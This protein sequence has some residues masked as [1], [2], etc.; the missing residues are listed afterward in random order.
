MSASTAPISKK[1]HSSFKS[2]GHPFWDYAAVSLLLGVLLW[3]LCTISSLGVTWDEHYHL[4]W[5]AEKWENYIN[6]FSGAINFSEFLQLRQSSVHPGF[7]DL[8]LQALIRGSSLDAGLASHLLSFSFGFSGLVAVWLTGRRLLGAMGGFF[9]LFLLIT[10]PRYFGHMWFNPKDIPFAACYMWSLYCLIRVVEGFPRPGWGACLSFGVL[11]GLSLGV[12]MAGLLLFCY[13]AVACCMFLGLHRQSLRESMSVFGGFIG[14]GLLS[15]VSAYLCVL[16][17]WPALWKSPFGG[18]TETV[19]EAQNFDWVGPVLYHGAFE[20]SN[21]LPWHY[22]PRWI[23]ITLPEWT[24]VLLVVS[25]FFIPRRLL[26]LARQ[27]RSASAGAG[28]SWSVIGLGALFP[29]AYVVFTGPTLYDGMR[30]FLFVLPPMVMLAAGGLC[31]GVQF[32]RE[33]DG[34]RPWLV[35]LP[36]GVTLC[37]CLAIV[38]FDYRALRPYYY[39][40]FNG[41]VGGLGGAYNHYETDYWGLSYREAMEILQDYVA[42]DAVAA[43]VPTS[44]TLAI[45]GSGELVAPFLPDEFKLISDREH[46]DFYVAYTR[47]NKHLKGQGKVVG[48]VRREGVPLNVIWDQRKI[49]SKNESDAQ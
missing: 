42:E 7:F 21:L 37:A 49:E 35:K 28:I 16:P 19:V 44:W 31:F 34:I 15:L 40:Y 22:L 29:V 30:H 11:T 32:L 43:D 41:W 46:A 2:R 5:G 12:R 24:L 45:S 20:V 8:L 1:L 10:A 38:L 14:K 3:G 6:W 36:I 25:A 39:V 48:I 27:D 17:F 9:A 47:V 18:V 26:Q 23:L 4:K 33:R 13:Y